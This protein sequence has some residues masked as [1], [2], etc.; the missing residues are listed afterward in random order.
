LIW[1]GGAELA[2]PTT[3]DPVCLASSAPIASNLG[4][5][6]PPLNGRQQRGCHAMPK[7]RLAHAT[8][9]RLDNRAFWSS[10]IVSKCG[11]LGGL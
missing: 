8:A 9:L 10:F 3:P 4:N 11:G 6:D 5:L 7:L 1:S 2:R